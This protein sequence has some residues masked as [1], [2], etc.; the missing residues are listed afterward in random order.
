MSGDERRRQ[1]ID[2]AIDLFAKK[3]FGGTTT[4]EI[5]TAAGVTEAIIFRHFATKQDLYQAILDTKCSN[6]FEDSLAAF[7]GYMDRDDDQGLFRF[8]LTK[9]VAFDREAP[10]LSRVLLHASLEGNEL[11]LMHNSQLALPIGAKFKEY[12][13][14][15]QAAGALRSMEPAVILYA[16]AGIANYFAMQK[17][18]YGNGNIQISDEQA[19]QGFLDIAMNGLRPHGAQEQAK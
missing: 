15:R 16:L 7:Q 8:L 18:I 11:A 19:I 17:Y 12:I 10:Q 3:G 2:V 4:R 14:R 6:G 9:I 13:A 5:A 1:L